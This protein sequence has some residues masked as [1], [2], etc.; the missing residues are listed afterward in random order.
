[1][2]NENDRVPD[3]PK[4]INLV[5]GEEQGQE[6]GQPEAEPLAEISV[7]SEEEIN[8]LKQQLA[9]A[10][11]KTDEYLDGWQRSRAEFANYK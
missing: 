6:F 3:E 11:A 9:E 4:K 7:L 2:E 1:M 5:E 10:R 8:N